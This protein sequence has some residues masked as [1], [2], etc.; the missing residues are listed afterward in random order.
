MT[1]SLVLVVIAALT[2]AAYLQMRSTSVQSATTRL[3]GVVQQMAAL[4]RNSVTGSVAG[5]REVARKPEVEAYLRDRSQGS[6]AAAL[7]ALR[8]AGNNPD[9]MLSVELH[10]MKGRTVLAAGTATRR[11][12]GIPHPDIILALDRRDT[13]MV[14]AFRALGDSVVYPTFGLVGPRSNPLG[15]LVQWRLQESTPQTR[16][17]VN[18]LI[19]PDATFLVGDTLQRSWTDLSRMVEGPSRFLRP[20]TDVERPQV[21]RYER[22]GR[23]MVYGA[24]A[25]GRGTEWIA[26][27]EFPEQIVVKASDVFLKRLLGIAAGLIVVALVAAAVLSRRLTGPLAQLATAADA[28]NRGELVKGVRVARNDE[29]GHVAEAFNRLAEGVRASQEEREE[30]FRMMVEQVQ[31]YAIFGLD[32]EGHVTTW[33]AGAQ[34]LKGYSE[35]EIVGKHFSR[36]YSADE[37]AAGKPTRVLQIAKAEGRI[38]DEGWRYRKDG[39]RFWANVVITAVHDREGKVTGFTKVTRDMTERRLGEQLLRE[40]TRELDETL[41]KLRVAQESLVRREKLAILGQLASGVGH[42]L[43]N[44]LGV[45]TNAIYFL[46]AVISD[47]PAKVKEYLGIL[48]AQVDLSEKI[49]SDLLD[50]A[51]V[52]PPQRQP[53]TLREV[54]QGQLERVTRLDGVKVRIDIPE[55][56]PPALADQVQVGQVVLN[57]L[58]NAM[59]AIGERGGTIDVRARVRSDKL[60]LEVADNGS[61]IAAENLERIFEPLFTTKARGMGLGL[62]VSRALAV[63]NGGDITVRS[64]EGEG[65]AFTLVLPVADLGKAA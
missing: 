36:F 39:S 27:V 65:A 53:V 54:V 25:R 30:R 20:G 56:L 35:Q 18:G 11:A 31:D 64:K 48:R 29:L 1:G 19:G 9:R 21:V 61:G 16:Q 41:A 55:N 33:N 37:I 26:L 17:T 58:T 8:Y 15:Y 14:G 45:M 52:K 47:P 34:R 22:P 44:P 23:G 38:E 49:V 4:L 46:E 13:A 12:A 7:A 28:I 40:R 32:A 62:A 43:R 60:V 10:D 6:R 57:L 42:E 63:A 5:I 3:Q 59:Q 50:F 24:T 51:R 2:V